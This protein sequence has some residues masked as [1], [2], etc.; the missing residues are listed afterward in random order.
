M[1]GKIYDKIMIATDGSK[2]V[3]KAIEAA[4]ELTKLT[5]A[6]LYA[7]YVIASTSYTPRSFGWEESLREI[8][9]A[10][11]KKAITFVEETGKASGVKVEPV[12]L[13]GYP[14]D[15]IME[16]AEQEGMDLIVMGTLGRTGLDRFL[17]GSIAEKVVRHSKIPV[18]VIKSEI[19]K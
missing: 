4:I 2:Q 12:I 11:A 15:R 3:E 7:I 17:L 13:E 8:L 18:M 9:E 19:A 5:G 6:R 16:F 10:E 14:A 1:E